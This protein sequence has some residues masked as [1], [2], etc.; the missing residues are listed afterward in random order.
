MEPDFGMAAASCPPPY[1]PQQTGNQCWLPVW[2]LPPSTINTTNLQLWKS[3][4]QNALTVVETDTEEVQNFLVTLE[5]KPVKKQ[6]FKSDM[7]L[8]ASK[9][10]KET[11]HSKLNSTKAQR[12]G[13]KKL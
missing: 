4:L 7:Y 11:F 2:W 3:T 10:K 8:Y 13:K 9:E 6:K 1:I 12:P 5:T